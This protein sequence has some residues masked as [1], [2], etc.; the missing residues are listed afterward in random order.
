[1]DD[2]FKTYDYAESDLRE[3]LGSNDLNENLEA[4]GYLL[5]TMEPIDGLVDEL[6]RLEQDSRPAPLQ[7]TVGDAASI[8]LDV[9][10]VRAYTGSHPGVK[11]YISQLRLT[12]PDVCEVKSTHPSSA[13]CS[14]SS[15]TLWT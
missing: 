2:R 10:G 7:L 4:L 15:V 9:H 1:M 6:L 14:A 3:L 5:E 13:R 8:L 12:L 11:D